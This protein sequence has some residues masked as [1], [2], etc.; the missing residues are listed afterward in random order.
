MTN[1][2]ETFLLHGVTDV[3]REDGYDLAYGPALV[4][5]DFI[6]RAEKLA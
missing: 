3:E 2:I 5:G 4:P 6:I 1:Q